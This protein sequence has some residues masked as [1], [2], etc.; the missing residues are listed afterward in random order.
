MSRP[1]P[2]PVRRL[3]AA[4][5]LLSAVALAGVLAACSASAGP[6][7]GG[8]VHPEPAVTSP[9]AGGAPTPAVT[10]YERAV[11]AAAARHLSVWLEADL[12]HRWK[13]GGGSLRDAVAQL[14]RLS[15]R[16]GV[17][18]VK[19]ADELGQDD[20]LN[21]QQQVLAFLADAS[22][23]V[24]AALPHTQILIDMVVPELG[25]MPAVAS[26]ASASASCAAQARE[27]WPGATTAVATAVVG[28][29]FIDVLDL[30]TGLRDDSYYRSWGLT[31]DAAQQ[32]AWARVA[33]LG[34]SGRVRLQARKALAQVGGYRGDDQQAAADLRTWV[35]IPLSSGAQAVDVWTWRQPY[36]GGVAALMDA[37][38]RDN[39]LWRGLLDR[40]SDRPR[41]LTHFTPSSTELGVPQ[42]LDRVTQ[43][44][45]SVFVA[46]G[47]G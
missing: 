7:P 34:W 5:R 44:F 27:R 38:L 2:G 32:A 24:R 17:V 11:D 41:L 26:V 36:R 40:S 29:G 20:G 42:D 22:G 1:R 47:T 33:A 45:G 46:A 30:S 6:T 23:A 4:G 19:I 10:R 3:A 18:G 21:D 16:P 9:G 39:A 43:V 15:A 25:C 31:R 8:P 37:G 35:D 14:A 13:E 12:V 28:S